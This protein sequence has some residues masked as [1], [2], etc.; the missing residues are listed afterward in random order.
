MNGGQ[1]AAWVHLLAA[2]TTTIIT[3][4]AMNPLWVVKTRLQLDRSLA[5]DSG[6]I[7]RRYKN[8]LDCT[9]QILRQEGVK[10]LYRGLSANYLGVVESTLYWVLYEQMK[11]RLHRREERLLASSQ[12]EGIW[13]KLADWGG[14]IGAA[15]S[16]KLIAIMA[17]YPH[18][19]RCPIP[20]V[21]S[22]I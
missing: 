8:S 11:L 2:A 18:E 9:L 10:G 20:L 14:K 7:G 4:T 17:T 6:K 16:S 3:G 21:P 13:D 19:V 15:G 5:T 12:K 22:S 1:E